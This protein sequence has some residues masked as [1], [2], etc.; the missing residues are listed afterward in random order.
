MPN[1]EISS[2]YNYVN[3]K[4]EGIQKSYTGY[5][6]KGKK[7]WVLLEWEMKDGVKH[8]YYKQFNEG[9]AVISE[10]NYLDGQQVS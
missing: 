5:E 2:E 10:Q 4:E 1:G 8:G 7:S 9:G 6:M 3:G